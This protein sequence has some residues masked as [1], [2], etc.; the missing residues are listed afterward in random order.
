MFD[1]AGYYSATTFNL[2]LSG[3]DTSKV[4]NMNCMFNSCQKL[5]TIYVGSGW[6]TSNVISSSKM[7]YGC[8]SLA[9]QSGATYNSSKVDKSMANYQTGYLTYKAPSMN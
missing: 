6:N 7:F 2:D 1:Y 5:K 3:W 4:T 9:G 8:T